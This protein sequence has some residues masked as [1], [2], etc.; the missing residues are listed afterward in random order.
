MAECRIYALG[1]DD[2]SDRAVWNFVGAIPNTANPK[3]ALEVFFTDC[4]DPRPLGTYQA[5]SDN[6]ST[7]Q[8]IYAGRQGAQE[9][10]LA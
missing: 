1:R 6:G 3:V 5:E 10:V 9:L 8:V 4:E 2:V 7:H